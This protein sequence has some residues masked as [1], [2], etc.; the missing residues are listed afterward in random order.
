MIKKVT[1]LKIIQNFYKNFDSSKIKTFQFLCIEKFF[2]SVIHLIVWALIA[3]SLGGNLFGELSYWLAITMILGPIIYL[4][5]DQIVREKISVKKKQYDEIIFSNLIFK[6]ISSIIVIVV[7]S[8]YIIH[9]KGLN[10]FSDNI[11]IVILFTTLIFRSFMVFEFFFDI[12]GKIQLNIFLRSFSFIS[13]IILLI[14]FYYIELNLFYVSI[15]YVSEFIILGILNIFIYFNFYQKNFIFSSVVILS[16][17]KR[18]IPLFLCDITSVIFSRI[19]YILLKDNV[20][21]EQIAS[22]TIAIRFTEVWY[23]AA[24]SIMIFMFPRII[25]SQQRK[26]QF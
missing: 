11:F 3:N 19:N 21:N 8:F 18:S 6:I 26:L 7:F 20:P 4:G 22:L 15:A 16:I 2:R 13:S 17:L 9:S 5:T 23:F 24:S 12:I 14:S 1:D 25:Q 10:F